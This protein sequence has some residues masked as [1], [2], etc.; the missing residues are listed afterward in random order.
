MTYQNYEGEVQSTQL[1]E[2]L[3]Q[4]MKC[5]CFVQTPS[6]QQRTKQMCTCYG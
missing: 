1:E 4:Y 2:N 6:Y 5:M 3:Q